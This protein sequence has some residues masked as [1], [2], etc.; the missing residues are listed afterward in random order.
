MI[1][2]YGHQALDVRDLGMGSASDV[3]I[4]GYA[5]THGLC[6]VTRDY[7]FADL[8]N[9]PPDRYAG[10]IVLSPPRDATPAYINHLLT[11]LLE[12][13]ELVADLPGKLAIVD[14]GR[15]RLRGPL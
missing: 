12:E 14:P 2:R 5:R 3:E 4:A 1:R 10:L 8:R 7:D 11:T 15:I 9:Y 13:E 6:L